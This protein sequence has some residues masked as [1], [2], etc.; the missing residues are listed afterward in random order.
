LK[1]IIN[2]SPCLKNGY[3]PGRQQI[4]G[5]RLLSVATLKVQSRMIFHAVWK[6]YKHEPSHFRELPSGS[7]ASALD[8]EAPN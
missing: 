5:A 8:K 7:S 1:A 6:K 3:P 4:T 2:Y